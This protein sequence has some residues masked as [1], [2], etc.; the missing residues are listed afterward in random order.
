MKGLPWMPIPDGRF[1]T[2]IKID[3]NVPPDFHDV[4]HGTPN[5]PMSMYVKEQYLRRYKHFTQGCPGCR[6]IEAGRP[7]GGSRDHTQACRNQLADKMSEDETLLTS[8]LRIDDETAA[9][10]NR[11]RGIRDYDHHLLPLPRGSLM[12][13]F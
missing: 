4:P 1:T 11:T 2:E 3:V 10:A 5:R 12:Q 7:G 13:Q 8:K 6:H 9:Y